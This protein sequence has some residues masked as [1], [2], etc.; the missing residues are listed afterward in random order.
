MGVDE[1]NTLTRRESKVY[2]APP[3]TN[4]TRVNE[5]INEASGEDKALTSTMALGE[6]NA[7]CSCLF[8]NPCVS[9]YNCKDW[10]NRFEVAKRHQTCG[11][12]NGIIPATVAL[13]SMSAEELREGGDRYKQLLEQCALSEV[14]GMG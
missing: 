10:A 2:V 6:D 13:K 4:I 1:D 5:P 11:T 3:S 14:L 9:P 12:H 7:S 8:G